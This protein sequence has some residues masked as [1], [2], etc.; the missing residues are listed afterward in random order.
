MDEEKFARGTFAAVERQN[1]KRNSQTRVVPVLGGVFSREPLGG[2]IALARYEAMLRI[3]A[4]DHPRDHVF[5]AAVDSDGRKSRHAVLAPG[6]SIVFGRH[7]QAGLRHHS[8]DLSLRHLAI[9]SAPSSTA[10][11][12][13]VR[14]WDLV[15][16]RA[17][18]TEDGTPA[19]AITANGPVFATVGA[20]FLAII[21]LGSL[22]DKLPIGTLALW[23]SLPERN[24]I[25]RVA[26]GSV[27]VPT[28]EPAISPPS[29][30]SRR[31]KVTQLMP[32]CGLEDCEPKMAVAELCLT[33]KGG[34]RQFRISMEALERG[35]LI[36][37]YERCLNL[38]GELSVLSR[39]HLLISK[40]GQD[41]VAIDTASTFGS[42][43]S[44]GRFDSTVLGSVD[45]MLLADVFLVEW[46][47][48]P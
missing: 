33:T 22:P 28:P 27:V 10:D 25:S 34:K 39:V 30:S 15:T 48:Q 20:V 42:S 43:K 38:G 9:A 3:A 12:P 41:V 45:D 46:K 1:K 6:D 23:H 31:T 19:T 37:R 32:V 7:D 16:G 18:K 44:S 13:L 29:T 24:V 8:D 36:G 35:I 21:P 47:F 17:F 2:Q 26:E 14:V 4:Q 40:M 5:V 11:D